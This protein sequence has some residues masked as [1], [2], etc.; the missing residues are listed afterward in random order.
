MPKLLQNTVKDSKE[1][2]GKEDEMFDDD[3]ENENELNNVNN[4]KEIENMNED[5]MNIRKL[6]SYVITNKILEI[7]NY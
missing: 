4:L 1:E 3:K 7:Q 6:W 2:I 5:I